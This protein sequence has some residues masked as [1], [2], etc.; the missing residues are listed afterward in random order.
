MR[1]FKRLKS[2]V[3]RLRGLPPTET[4]IPGQAPIPLVAYYD[5]LLSYYPNCEMATKQWFI[6]N[7]REDWVFFDCGANIGY[8]A[9]LFSRLAP[10]GCV[11]AF[12]PTRTHVMLLQNLRHNGAENVVAE[13]LALGRVS[14]RTVAR[15]PRI[16]GHA[17]DR[18]EFEFTTIDDYVRKRRIGRADCIKIDVDSYDFDVLLGAEETLARFR[19]RLVIELTDVALALRG[20]FTTEVLAWLATRGYARAIVLD[21]TNYAFGSPG[22]TTGGKRSAA[23]LTLDFVSPVR[24]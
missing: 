20:V 1:F 5:E 3:K 10:K 8:Y 15:L 24:R 16:W 6:E 9:L 21:Q 7:S 11:Y 22:S 19:P 4:L 18:G 17:W 2:Q 13:K 23:S 14:G 12:E